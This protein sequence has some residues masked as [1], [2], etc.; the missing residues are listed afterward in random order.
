MNSPLGFSRGKLPSIF[1]C[2]YMSNGNQLKIINDFYYLGVVLTRTFNCKKA[3]QC[4]IDKATKALYEI[5]KLSLPRISL[6]PYP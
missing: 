1:I 6:V 5:L 2:L 3:K 4:Q